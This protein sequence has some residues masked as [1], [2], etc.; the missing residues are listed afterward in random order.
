[1]IK[2]RSS[3]Q[4]AILLSLAEVELYVA[5]RAPSETKGVYSLAMDFS[6]DPRIKTHVGAQT[7]IGRSH[8]VGLGNARH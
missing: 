5:T 4:E 6:E 2:H 8:R 3:T 7:M 1:M